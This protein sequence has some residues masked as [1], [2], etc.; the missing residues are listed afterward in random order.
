[1]NLFPYQ[2]RA[3]GLARRAYAEGKRAILYVA[4][5]GAGKTVILGDT[6]ASHVRN[7]PGARVNVYAHRRELLHQ[8]AATFRALG[9]DVGVFGEGAAHPV[10]I[11]S[12]QGVLAKGE[13]QSCTLAV[14]DEA[15]H[16]AADEWRAVFDAHKNAKTPIVGATATPE[17]GDGRALDMF[18]HIVVVAQPKELIAAGRLVPCDWQGP[19]RKVP[20]GKLARTPLFAHQSLSR[21]RRNVIFAPN[22]KSA[23]E[24]MGHFQ[25]AG[26]ASGMVWGAQKAEE[27]DRTLANFRAGKLRVVFNCGVLTEGYDDPGIGMITIARTVGSAGMLIQMAGRGARVAPG[28]D[29]YTLA[30]LAG[31]CLTYGLPDDDREFSLEGVGI[32]RG[33][34]SLAAAQRLCKRCKS[35]LLEDVC[36]RCGLDNGQE[37]PGDAGI[38][39]G[40]WDAKRAA[41]NTPDKRAA[42]LARWMQ[43]FPG[44]DSRFYGF[45]FK[46]VYGAWPT[47]EVQRLAHEM[48]R[49]RRVG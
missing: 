17:R 49:G 34:G 4:P 45:R 28:K 39:L 1:M 43:K 27:R 19:K 12:T 13:V 29:S 18:D 14:F 26:V 15:H 10:Q 30:D 24:W 9:L 46:S 16:Y 36:A 20:K 5:T 21:G 42:Q 38:E 11:M 7:A 31:A 23:R 48:V 33:S 32:S 40:R 2:T 6:I 35:E 3:R 37:V 44:K 47:S 25:T 22:L 8:A 41:D